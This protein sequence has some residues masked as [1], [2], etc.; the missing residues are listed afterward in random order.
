QGHKLTYDA[1]GN[2]LSDRHWDKQI[3]AD[4][5]AT[6]GYTTEIYAYDAL[7]RLSTTRRDGYLLDARYYDAADRV[8]LSGID[9]SLGKAFFDRSGIAGE[10]QRNTYDAAGRL[11]STRTL[12]MT[13]RGLASS[14]A[15]TYMGH[16]GAGNVT[17]YRLDVYEGRPYSNTYTYDYARDEGYREASLSGTST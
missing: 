1:N 16:D 3:H 14:H 10:Q 8:V 6:A 5:S 2:R 7:N 4:G 11:A 17:Q 9:G 13:A 12:K 15:T